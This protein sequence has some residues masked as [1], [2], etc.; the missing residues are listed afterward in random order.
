MEENFF[1]IF[2][3][4]TAAAEHVT[5]PMSVLLDAELAIVGGGI[6]DTVL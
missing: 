5:C 4:D 3:A 1:E 2:R 6:G